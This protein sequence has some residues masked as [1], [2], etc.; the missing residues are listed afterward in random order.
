MV[1][2]ITNSQCFAAFVNIVCL[3][4]IQSFLDLLPYT[5]QCR[6]RKPQ[7]AALWLGTA[8][9][10]HRTTTG[11]TEDLHITKPSASVIHCRPGNARPVE[12]ERHA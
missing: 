2:I 5:P 4:R 1:I 3:L 12:D 11:H 8:R 7:S 10:T 9:I 6:T